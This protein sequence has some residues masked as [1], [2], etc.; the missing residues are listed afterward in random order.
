ML[1]KHVFSFAYQDQQIPFYAWS[2]LESNQPPTTVVFLGTGQT[3]RIPYW[4]ARAATPGTVVV[5]GAPHWK[6]HPSGHDLYDFMHAFTAAALQSARQLFGLKRLHVV[7]ESQAAPGAVVAACKQPELIHNVV[8]IA[9]NG[10]LADRLGNSP[11]ARLRALRRRAV[12]S[13]LQL[14]QS[15]LHDPR[16]LYAGLMIMRAMLAEAERGASRRKYAQGLSYDMREDCRK[17]LA[18]QKKTGAHC[19]VLLGTR[20]RLFPAHEVADAIKTAGLADLIVQILPD[21]THSSLATR[22][23]RQ[24]LQTAL[25]LA[26]S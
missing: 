3:G 8:L 19:T 24:A 12:K 7:A 10:F 20:D 22:G 5:Q 14:P 26:R 1:Q 2:H 23:G 18:L 25:K 16:N 4:V 6:S 9:P 17:L 13:M 21:M 11:E 15:P